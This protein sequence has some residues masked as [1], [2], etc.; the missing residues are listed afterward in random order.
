[1]PARALGGRLGPALAVAGLLA[2]ATA[3]SHPVE[4]PTVD[5]RA[6]RSAAAVAE[7]GEG[8]AVGLDR[9]SPTQVVVPVHVPPA[10][11]SNRAV[12][13]ASGTADRRGP[14]A[15]Q[16]LVV[17]VPGP[18][19]APTTSTTSPAP[20]APGGS[21]SGAGRD[22]DRRAGPSG[23]SGAT[24]SAG[25]FGAGTVPLPRTGADLLTW[26]LGVIGFVLVDAGLLV[27]W[28]ARR[29]ERRQTFT[30]RSPRG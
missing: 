28:A 13:G 17:V 18:A 8:R 6:P 21:S 24:G 14:N 25:R 15:S 29:L 1:M 12:G 4:L 7:R 5:V 10:L 2:G 20:P 11:V 3:W 26:R 27:S 19:P 22:G 23:A 30:W 16:R 9:P